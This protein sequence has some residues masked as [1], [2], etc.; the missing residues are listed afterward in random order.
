MNSHLG[1]IPRGGETFVFA[2]LAKLFG[3]ES[4][5]H[6]VKVSHLLGNHG[7]KEKIPEVADKP[8]LF[9]GFLPSEKKGLFVV[10]T[11][12]SAVRESPVG[13]CCQEWSR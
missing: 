12:L 7:E 3:A 9:V 1:D 11:L 10:E 5:E 4:A 2:V 13:C 8:W 6:K